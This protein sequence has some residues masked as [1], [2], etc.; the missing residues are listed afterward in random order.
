MTVHALTNGLIRLRNEILALRGEREEF[1]AHLA[2]ETMDRRG[3]VS[4][5]LAQFSKDCNA[6]ARG[7]KTERIAFLASLKSTVSKLQNSVR[8]DL[9]GVRQAFLSLRTASPRGNAG[10]QKSATPVAEARAHAKQCQGATAVKAAESEEPAREG[11]KR[12]PSQGKRR[13]AGR[14]RHRE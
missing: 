5:M 1:L 4:Q 6:V 12:E 2:Q 9:G 11:K 3:S 7:T 14:P 13:A 8:A 10:C